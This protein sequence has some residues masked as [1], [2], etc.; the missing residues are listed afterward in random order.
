V[1]LLYLKQQFFLINIC[2]F[3]FYLLPE[4]RA[5]KDDG[6]E[7][8][9]AEMFIETRQPRKGKIDE[10]TEAAVVCFFFLLF[11]IY[12]FKYLQFFLIFIVFLLFM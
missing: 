1:L 6:E 2:Y 8:T 4:K 5:K 12:S 7:V 3:N 11:L 9:Q 10:E